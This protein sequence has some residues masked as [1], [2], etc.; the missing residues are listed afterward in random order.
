MR[1]G[2]QVSIYL[3][4]RQYIEFLML[5]TNHKRNLY[6]Q[7]GIFVMTIL[8]I[9]HIGERHSVQVHLIRQLNRRHAVALDITG[10]SAERTDAD[11]K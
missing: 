1:P 3:N 10:H 9:I 6:R 4:T 2:Q 5:Y 7:V 8:D 11:V